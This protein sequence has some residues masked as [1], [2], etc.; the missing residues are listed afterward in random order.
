[1][2]EALAIIGFV[3]AIADLV[4]LGKKVIGRLNEFDSARKEVPESFRAI[5]TQLPLYLDTLQLMKAQAETGDI[6]STSAQAL[7][8]VVS[9]SI[10]LTKKLENIL[11]KALPPENATTF[12]KRL[13]A[14]RSLGKDKKVLECRDKLESNINLLVFFQTTHHSEKSQQILSVLSQ[15]SLT[16]AT[17]A[18]SFGLDTLPKE[19]VNCLRTLYTSDYEANRRSNPPRLPGTCAWLLDHSQYREWHQERVSSLLWLSADAGCGKSVLS[20]YLIE[21]LRGAESQAGLPGIVCH[22]FLKN[23]VDGILALQ[24]L[25][26]QLFVQ[27]P[28]SIKYAM[29]EYHAKGEAFA[30]EFETLWNIFLNV[31]CDSES[32]NIICVLDALDECSLP[33]RGQLLNLLTDLFSN[34]ASFGSPRVKFFVTSR[35]YPSIERLLMNFHSVRLE[36]EAYLSGVTQD[37]TL[38][39]Q[40]R[41]SK[42]STSKGLS[43]GQ[44]HDLRNRLLENADRTFLWIS[45]VLDMIEDTP[46]TS[47]RVRDHMLST[48]PTKLEDTY[49]KVLS[50][51]PAADVAPARKVMYIMLAATEPLGVEEMN[52]AFSIS[53]EDT[54]WQ[55]IDFEASI[56]DYVKHIL[57][58]LVKVIDSKFYF[59]HHTVKEFLSGPLQVQSTLLQWKHTFSPVEANY[60]L[61]TSCIRYLMLSDFQGKVDPY[62][63]FRSPPD[64]LKCWTPEDFSATE[65]S[66]APGSWRNSEDDEIGEGSEL[67][68]RQ[69]ILPRG[70]AQT[71][72]AAATE[73]GFDQTLSQSSSGSECRDSA[74]PNDWKRGHASHALEDEG[75]SKDDEHEDL[76][77]VIESQSSLPGGGTQKMS[78]DAEHIDLGQTSFQIFC[79]SSIDFD[80]PQHWM[81]ILDLSES[82]QVGFFIYA[83]RYWSIH[84]LAAQA[85]S[86]EPVEGIKPSALS[87]CDS[88]SQH[89]QAWFTV[90]HGGGSF[91]KFDCP[92]THG[93][94]LTAYL[95]LSNVLPLI[96]KQGVD[97][98]VKDDDGNTA[99]HIVILAA[100]RGRPWKDVLE[101]LLHHKLDPDAQNRNGCTALHVAIDQT[102]FD[103]Q[104]GIVRQIL[105]SRPNLDVLDSQGVTPLHCAAEQGHLKIV[106]L[107]LEHGSTVDLAD[108]SDE[109]PLFPAVYNGHQIVRMLLNAGADK[110]KQNRDGNTPLVAG[111][112]EYLYLVGDIDL[113]VS[114]MD[115]APIQSSIELMVTY[116]ARMPRELIQD[117]E[118][119]AGHTLQSN[120]ELLSWLFGTARR[121]RLPHFRDFFKAK[122]FPGFE[123]W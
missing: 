16:P 45:L 44:Q 113:R 7:E 70:R 93:L 52:T 50:N 46:S 47:K 94:H 98:N 73:L 18:S 103:Q 63:E 120:T 41:V 3:A 5:A 2:A 77:G 51:I 43:A 48:I 36:G 84:F 53:N 116:Q 58:R 23:D 76:G 97:V 39:V 104:E 101:W 80:G 49:E 9:T 26:H 20:S 102:E 42:I 65:Q 119:E 31:I 99:L 59:V 96:L 117:F 79:E 112:K 69:G 95:G 25:L 110:E 38:V 109:T 6:S 71:M 56:V 64:D 15:L 4:E 105:E 90:W 107:L 19:H 32:Q 22:Y 17:G 66:Q 75:D 35:P 114:K 55:E 62:A 60:I 37:I 33:S 89:F 88:N 123:L 57:P 100:A 10:D 34:P 21:E 118:D 78:T 87:L 68:E 91:H 27:D 72:S 115:V 11:A 30:K 61:A 121:S 81:R 111:I 13:A 67:I 108:R 82:R 24:A 14:L 86:F 85:T 29:S 92:S 8:R 83:A 28:S 122:G 54:S 12:E 1:M 74:A 40:E 106:Q